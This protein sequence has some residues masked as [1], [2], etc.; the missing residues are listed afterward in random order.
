MLDPTARLH[1]GRGGKV[2]V[3][4]K[5]KPLAVGP[6]PTATGHGGR[7]LDLTARCRGGRVGKPSVTRSASALAVG[8]TLPP[9][10]LEV[11][12]PYR[13]GGAFSCHINFTPLPP[14]PPAVGSC[15]LPPQALAVGFEP[16]AKGLLFFVT[17][18]MPPYRHGPLQ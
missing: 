13:Q 11:G 16:T 5:P 7:V 9:Q 10:A 8:L 18:T 1:G 2:S 14:W 4:K 3:T 12:L 17:E 6:D 15:N